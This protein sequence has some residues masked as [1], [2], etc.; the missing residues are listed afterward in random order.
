MLTDARLHQVV[1]VGVVQLIERYSMR[2]LQAMRTASAWPR[3]YLRKLSYW[4]LIIP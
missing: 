4:R 2:T 1:M 3:A